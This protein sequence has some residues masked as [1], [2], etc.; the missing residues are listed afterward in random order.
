M[1]EEALD[2]CEERFTDL[3]QAATEAFPERQ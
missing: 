2:Y 3:Y 1:T